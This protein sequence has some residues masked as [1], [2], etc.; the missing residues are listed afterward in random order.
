MATTQSPDAVLDINKLGWHIQ[1]DIKTVML[2]HI[3]WVWTKTTSETH[4]VCIGLL[5]GNSYRC[6]GT[7]KYMVGSIG[8]VIYSHNMTA[9]WNNIQW[10]GENVG[11]DLIF[12]QSTDCMVKSGSFIPEWSQLLHCDQ[13]Y[14]L[15]TFSLLE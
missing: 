13:N 15:K 2:I 9:N 5:K 11:W 14:K 3:T 8:S 10:R 4:S 1:Y 12:I 7:L 6:L